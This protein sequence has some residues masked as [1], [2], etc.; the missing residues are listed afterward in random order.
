MK[1]ELDPELVLDL[2]HWM[3][4]L[5]NVDEERVPETN[6]ADSLAD[7]LMGQVLAFLESARRKRTDVFSLIEPDGAREVVDVLGSRSRAG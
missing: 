7:S 5:R 6:F 2:I 4:L 3:L 1:L